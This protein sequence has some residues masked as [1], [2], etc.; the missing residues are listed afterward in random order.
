MKKKKALI[1]MER[2]MSGWDG[3]ALT[4]KDVVIVIRQIN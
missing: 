1:I 4:E 2:T 3:R